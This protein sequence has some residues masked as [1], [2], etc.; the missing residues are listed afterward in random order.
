MEEFRTHSESINE[1]IGALI[2]V[3][4]VLESAAKENVN[5]HFKSKYADLTSIWE[6]C[7]EPLTKN[8]FAVTQVVEGN[9]SDMYL[10]TWL[11][12]TSGQWMRSRI[13]LLPEKPGSQ[14]LGSAITYARRYALAAIVGVCSDDDDGEKAMGRTGKE[15]KSEKVKLMDDEVPASFMNQYGEDE[16][17]YIKE[18]VK[19][20]SKHHGKDISSALKDFTDKSMFDKGYEVWKNKHYGRKEKV[21]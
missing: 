17:P 19:A 7:K 12:H 18:Y 21:A 10:T 9:K 4:A 5:S 15:T 1:L 2:K 6:A 16:R 11:M 20:Y 14:P 3:Q 8:G 13:P